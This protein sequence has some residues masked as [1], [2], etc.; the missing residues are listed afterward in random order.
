MHFEKRRDNYKYHRLAC[1]DDYDF[2]KQPR[3]QEDKYDVWERRGEL[4]DLV[5]NYY[6]NNVDEKVK[7]YAKDGEYECDEENDI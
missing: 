5:I 2:N 1:E 4:F 6:R 3:E 7:Y